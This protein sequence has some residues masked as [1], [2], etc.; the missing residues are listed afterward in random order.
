VRAVH[1][2]GAGDTLEIARPEG[3]PVMVPFTRAIVPSVDLAAGRLVVDPPPGL[4]DEPERTRPRR[5][6][7]A[8]RELKREKESA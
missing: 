5:E 8:K 4:L 1:D 3:P 2:F 6:R 7:E